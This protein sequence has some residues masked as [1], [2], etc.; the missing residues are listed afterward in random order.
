MRVEA[1]KVLL[2]NVVVIMSRY[3]TLEALDRF[4]S[5]RGLLTRL[6]R[7]EVDMAL[8]DLPFMSF[9]IKKTILLCPEVRAF[10]LTCSAAVWSL[11]PLAF[12]GIAPVHW[13]GHIPRQA[14]PDLRPWVQ[15]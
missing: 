6:R 7:L 13:I 10:D 5:P 12:E 14:I 2:E 9:Q 3:T 4:I 11:P 8:D 15:T 1:L